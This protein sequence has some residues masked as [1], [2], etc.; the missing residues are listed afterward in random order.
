MKPQGMDRIP[1]KVHSQ[2]DLITNSST[3]IFVKSKDAVNPAKEL[4]AELL[5][6]Q[7]INK[8]VDELFNVYFKYDEENI[9]DFIKYDLEWEDKELYEKLRLDEEGEKDYNKRTQ[10]IADYAN[11]IMNGTIEIPSWIDSYHIQ[12][13]LIV[14]AKD[15]KYSKFAELLIKLLT[16]QEHY[17]HSWG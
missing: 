8:P 16:S 3:E 17:E 12:T 5:K 9:K 2:I 13:Y 10:I 1:I 15:E 14:E 7:G 4:L 6:V 11:G